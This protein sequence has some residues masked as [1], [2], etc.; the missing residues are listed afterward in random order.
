MANLVK[1]SGK[2]TSMMSHDEMKQIEQ[3]RMRKLDAIGK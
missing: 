2:S 3:R 1:Y